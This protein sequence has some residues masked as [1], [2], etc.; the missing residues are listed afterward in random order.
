MLSTFEELKHLVKYKRCLINNSTF[1]LHYQFTFTLLCVFSLIQT[2]KQHLGD[3]IMCSPVGTFEKELVNSYCWI[4]G[5][6]IVDCGDGRHCLPGAGRKGAGPGMAGSERVSQ[7][8]Y[9]W[10]IFVLFLQALCCYFPHYLWKVWEG[11]KI[12]LLIQGLDGPTLD[13]GKEATEQKRGVI[14]NYFYKNNRTHNL[15]VAKFVFCEFLNLVNM[16][17]QMYLM[18]RFFSG[19]FLDY[20]YNIMSSESG[21]NLEKEIIQV[22]PKI[23]KCSVNTY[24]VSGTIQ[25]LDSFCVLPLNNFNGKFYFFLW[26]WYLLVL[27]WTSIF[28]CFRII[29]IISR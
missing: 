25:T 1:K 7:V 29:T 20:G 3:P 23:G 15:Y 11:K 13:T 2:L 28:F 6:Y 8:W 19:S 17:G 22:F 9:Q 5:T 10:V 18:D 14:V 16:I 21:D 26:F 12:S 24:G 27:S 4:H